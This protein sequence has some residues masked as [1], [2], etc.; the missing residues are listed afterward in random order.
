M[1]RNGLI[2]VLSMTLK[3]KFLQCV[4]S[5]TLKGFLLSPLFFNIFQPPDLSWPTTVTVDKPKPF[6][7]LKKAKEK[8]D[9]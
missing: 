2:T 8:I 9:C 6:P 3:G 7:E 4:L 5:M 1:I